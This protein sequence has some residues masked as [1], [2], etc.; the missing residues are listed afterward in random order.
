[1]NFAAPPPDLTAVDLLPAVSAQLL[2]HIER[3]RRR[4]WEVSTADLVLDDQA[5]LATR[6]HPPVPLERAGFDGLLRHY[7]ACFPRAPTLLSRVSTPL[8]VSVWRELFDPSALPLD[9]KVHERAGSDGTRAVWGVSPPSYP[10][11]YHVGRLLADVVARWAG[12]PPLARMTYTADESR[13]RLEVFAPGYSV[14]VGS[15]DQYDDGGVTV[16]VLQDGKDLGDPL[17]ALKSRRRGGSVDAAV[18]ATVAESIIA[19]VAA[20]PK[21]VRGAR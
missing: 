6:G 9:L 14:V 18:G 19:K 3:E 8:F 15:V 21:L 4:S 7:A 10:S 11:Q 12:A 5:R 16:S 2:A 1:M 17:P 13:L 20:A